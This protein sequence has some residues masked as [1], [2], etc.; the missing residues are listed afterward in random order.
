MMQLLCNGTY[1]DLYEDAGLQLKQSNPLFVFDNIECERTTNIKLPA[2]PTNDAVL[3]CARVPAYAGTGMRQRF[4]AQLIAGTIVKNGYLYVTSFDGKDYNAVFVTGQML[5]LQAIKDAGKI[6]EVATFN[7][8][9]SYGT[10]TSQAMRA[11]FFASINYK[12]DAV[13][14][15]SL[16]LRD[17]LI[18][19]FDELGVDYVLPTEPQYVRYVPAEAKGF[20]EQ[21]VDM[22]A[23]Q[24][25]MSPNSYPVC[26]A[27]QQP[28][29]ASIVSK[30][31]AKVGYEIAGTPTAFGTVEQFKAWQNLQITFPDDW[32]DDLFIGYFESTNTPAEQCLFG[33]FS[34]YSDRSFDEDGNV[35]GESLRG[36]TVNIPR[37]A[38]FVII[39]KSGYVKQ[40]TSGGLQKGWVLP[41]MGCEFTLS[42][43][44]LEMG[45]LLRA[46]DNLPDI[47]VT[48]LL[49]VY[50][51]LSGKQ[52]YYTDADGI[53]FDA[54]DFASWN[55]LD[56]TDKL[57]KYAEVKR[58]FADYAQ[59]N[60]VKFKDEDGAG[61]PRIV[62]D[63]PINNTNIG[64]E[65]VLQEI[66]YS[67]GTGDGVDGDR[68]I[69]YIPDGVAALADPAIIT[70]TYMMRPLLLKSTGVQAL[71]TASTSI[72]V[73][74][75]MTLLEYDAITPK[76]V[77][78]LDGTRYVWAESQWSKDTATLQLSKIA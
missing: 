47:T 54:L 5:G 33:L 23:Q 74:A 12:S 72:K 75:R 17:L 7:G 4:A 68:T 15:P 25:S 36:R 48:E 37:N 76:T 40:S 65:K 22:K 42:G 41:D 18:E 69:A 24:G 2:T 58:I 8:T 9:A 61:T 28:A 26:Y 3:T 46:Q 30:H 1:L 43:G 13:A 71:C 67:E 55:V 53:T 45:S 50:A 34:F 10:V 60:L 62:V 73:Q 20:T 27:L 57:I 11:T 52:L 49:K 21:V 64:S 63:Y 39:N 78:M 31:T 38:Y 35:E 6:A 44:E 29:Y 19:T 56:I 70:A 59:H 14:K 77:L 32:D 66:P 51:A 16:R